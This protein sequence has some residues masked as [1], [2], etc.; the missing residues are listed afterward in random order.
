[1]NNLNIYET[2]YS[3]GEWDEKGYGNHRAVINVTD[4]SD[5]NFAHIIWRRKD[6][7]PQDKAIIIE[8]EKGKKITDFYVKE[9]NRI[10]GD[11]I[12]KPNDIGIYYIYY[13]P[14]IPTTQQN[15]PE[16]GYFKPTNSAT[17][18][19]IKKINNK[20]PTSNLIKIEARK[21]ADVADF[22]SMYPMEIIASKEETQN[23]INK[24]NTDF[25]LFSED[26]HHPIKMVDD[27]PLHWIKNGPQNNFY[28]KAHPNE[29]Y[30]FQIG[31]FACNKDIKNI[32]IDFKNLKG[33]TNTI[34]SD[35][36]TCF[37]LGGINCRGNKFTK[38]VNVKAKQVQDLWIGVDIPRNA[39]GEYKGT[40]EISSDNSKAT[41]FNLV[42]NVNGDILEDKG[43]SNQFNLSRLRWLNDPI[44]IEDSIVKPYTNVIINNNE[45]EILDRK[46]KFNNNGLIDSIISRENE[47]LRSPIEFVINKE[48]K[49]LIFNIDESKIIDSGKSFVTH[50]SLL[51]NEDLNLNINSKIEFDGTIT[52]SIKLK[53]KKDL[54]LD[55]IY[56]YC[57]IK[58]EIAT[59]MLGMGLKGGY[60]PKEHLWKWAEHR[61]DNYLW[62][63]DIDAG[64]QLNLR[65]QID[66]WQLYSQLETGCPTSWYN[67]G[68]GG[69]DIIED[70]NIVYI[71]AYSGK[72]NIKSEEEIE[73][74]FRLLI[75]PFHKI[76]NE[77]WDYRYDV[78]NVSEDTKILH[79]HHAQPSYEYINY[80]FYHEKELKNVIDNYKETYKK[81]TGEELKINLYYTLRELTNYLPELWAF[82][83]LDYEI[84]KDA[85]FFRNTQKEML[86]TLFGGTCAWLKEHMYIDLYP[87]WKSYLGNGEVDAA[88]ST[89]GISRLSNFYV[90]GF[91]YL[92]KHLNIDGLYLDSIGYDR[93]IIQRMA[94]VMEKNNS[95]YRINIHAYNMFNYFDIKTNPAITYM[96]HMIYTNSLWFGE[97]FDYNASPD[98]WLVAISGIPYGL[99]SEMLIYKD[100]PINQYRGMIYGMSVRHLNSAKY[101]WRFWDDFGIKD[102][103]WIGYWEKSCPVKTNNKDVLATCYVKEDKI[104]IAIA[105]WAKNNTNIKLDIDFEAIG[106]NKD[107]ATLCAPAIQNFQD[108]KTFDIN[109]EILVEKDRGWLLVLENLT[110]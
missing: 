80:P 11:I 107:K 43:D 32:K 109:E 90:K 13:L 104:L 35:N 83:S 18:E 34:T 108:E 53:A 8:N 54:I 41:T 31:F 110:S 76:D 103:K 64:I 26:R 70:N 15:E 102:S 92:I 73:Y 44:G 10:Y 86:L 62:I 85:N 39:K 56:L 95:Y 47:I 69:C 22:N 93:E 78:N 17:S 68:N 1:V 52:Y 49:E 37:N 23:L 40:L 25:L 60:R 100:L 77:H 65:N 105:S 38:K 55:D 14:Y 82:E 67:N 81:L 48:N 97:D 33:E 91:E 46:V 2:E 4:T 30:V 101:M 21:N 87:E 45:I 20:L 84:Y 74:N 27:L 19:L 96:E 36:L 29:Y 3:I 63:G 75:T 106:I 57:P 98:H 9:I 88:I 28:G 24:Y 94:R 7:N 16:T 51:S 42:L 79:M 50:N 72:K 99:T 12:F 66:N 6:H 61:A 71:K 59:Y 5:Y 89:N 58:K